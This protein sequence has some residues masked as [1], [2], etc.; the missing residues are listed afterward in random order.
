MSTLAG[1][2]WVCGTCRS[3]NNAGANQCYNCRAP[4]DVAEVD[5]ATIDAST[6][7]AAPETAALPDFRSS[8]AIALLASILI[9]AV[10]GIQIVYTLVWSNVYLEGTSPAADAERFVETVGVVAL[11]IGALALIAWALWLSRAVTSM[12]ALGLGYPSTSGLSAFLENFFPIV[13]LVR[14][15]PIVRDVVVRLESTAGRSGT[16]ISAAWIGLWAG[17]L[18]PRVAWLMVQGDGTSSSSAADGQLVLQVIG[19]GL[20]LASATVLVA[21]IWWIE[22]RIQRRRAMQVGE[23]TSAP[24]IAKAARPEARPAPADT[25]GLDVV[26]TRSAFA[27]GGTSAATVLASGSSGNGIGSSNGRGPSSAPVPVTAAIGMAAG[28]GAAVAGSAGG[29]GEPDPT[30]MPIA[31]I[32]ASA[33]VIEDARETAPAAEE[34]AIA[35]TIAV[36]SAPAEP[37]EPAG[38]ADAPA[39]PVV[40][41]P[42]PPSLDTVV[43]AEPAEPETARAPHLT[44]TIGSHGMMTAELDGDTEHVILDDLTAYGSA[45]AKVGGTASIAVKTGDSMAE[46]VARRARRIL[47]DVGVHIATD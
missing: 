24:M 37:A 6:P 9:L 41:A 18:V 30:G 19:T 44:I 1:D 46:L 32:G 4:R 38:L 26:A 22:A 27:A 17:F 20:V 31:A 3:I 15:P 16:L 23:T 8:R 40:S 28:A 11:G 7:A 45:L 43:S 10:V 2:F 42:E 13:N 29:G 14:V 21:L 35:E 12:P 25:N 5:P 47:E 33:V 36:T 34:S 39:A